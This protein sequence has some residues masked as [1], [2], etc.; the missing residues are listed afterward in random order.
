MI[1]RALADDGDLRLWSCETGR[2]ERGRAFVEGLSD[3]L[4]AERAGVPVA[5]WCRSFGWH[6]GLDLPTTLAA[7]AQRRHLT[8][9]GLIV[10]TAASST[11]TLQCLEPYDANTK[12]YTGY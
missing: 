6:V 4:G 5:H 2:G 3:A 8:E 1:G 12:G 11:T 7:F 10:D 9:I